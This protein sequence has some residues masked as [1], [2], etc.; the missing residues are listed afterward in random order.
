VS[1]LL[2]VFINIIL[3]SYSMHW[4]FKMTTKLTAWKHI[5][6]PKWLISFTSCNI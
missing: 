6:W 3:H 1:T 5:Q 4:C 2:A